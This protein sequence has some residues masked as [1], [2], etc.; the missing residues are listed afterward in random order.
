[1]SAPWPTP[2]DLAAYWMPFTADGRKIIDAAAV[3]ISTES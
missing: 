3:L 2:N 1:M